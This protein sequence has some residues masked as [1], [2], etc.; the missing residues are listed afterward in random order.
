MLGIA[1]F[2]WIYAGHL[3]YYGGK[4]IRSDGIAYYLYLPAVFLDHDL[5]MRTTVARDFGGNY[6]NAGDVR[7]VGPHTYDLD[8]VGIGEAVLLTPFFAIGQGIAVATGT[9]QTGFTWPYQAAAAAAG[10]TYVL[11]GLAL[12]VSILLRWFRRSTVIV[13][14]VAITF[15]TDLFHYA[16]YDALFSHAF[17]FFLIAAALRL[18]LS[19]WQRPRVASTVALAAGIGLIG[20]VRPTNLVAVALCALVGIEHPRDLRARLR[21]LARRF[22]LV[23]IGLGVFVT[24]SLPQ[25]AYWHHITGKLVYYAYP[26]SQHLDLLHPHVLQVLFSVRKGLFFWT[27]VLVCAVAGLGRLRRAVPPLFVPAVVYLLAQLWVVSS[28]SVWSYGGSFGMRPFVE[29][30]PVF[31]LGLAALIEAARGRVARRI[32]YGAIGLTTAL[33]VHA[34]VAYWLKT[35][36][37]DNTTLHEYLASFYSLRIASP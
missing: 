2:A 16:T 9:P 35:V 22:D 17:S 13:S 25:L 28:W 5:T 33:G 1:S 3:T 20:I 10:L 31:A 29:A 30:M 32:L 18:S 27:P 19:V 12:T 36:P 15:G 7:Q 34:M 6:V 11:L 14:L 8:E 4:P 21:T 23:A 26:P 24:V 37:Y